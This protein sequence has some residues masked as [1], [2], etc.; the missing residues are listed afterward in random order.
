M[1]AG[2]SYGPFVQG[3]VFSGDIAEDVRAFFE[4]HQDPE[5]QSIELIE[6]EFRFPKIIHQNM[7]GS[8]EGS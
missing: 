2:K 8:S 5:T 1:T 3:V 7:S 6:E 4:H